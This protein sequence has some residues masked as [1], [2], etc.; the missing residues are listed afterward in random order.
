MTASAGSACSLLRE[1]NPMFMANQEHLALF[2]QGTPIWNRW[3]QVHPEI[4]P[5]LSGSTLG[6]LNL[7]GANFRGANLRGCRLGEY[8]LESSDWLEDQ[9]KLDYH[10][11]DLSSANLS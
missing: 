3:R 11:V 1:R 6:L 8:R 4:Q 10:G 7:R 9:G 2:G 5:N